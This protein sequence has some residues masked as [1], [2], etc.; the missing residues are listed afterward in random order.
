ME[1]NLTDLVLRDFEL[2]SEEESPSEEEIFH[3]LCD[4]IAYM[5]EHQME[6]LLSLLYRN[7][8]EESKIN[9]ALSP[10]APE[11]PHIGLAHFLVSRWMA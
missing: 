3:L 4:R 6:Y 2:A 11:P 5:I 8:V 1:Y 9:F 10:L 7:D